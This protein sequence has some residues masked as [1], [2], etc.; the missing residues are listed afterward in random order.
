MYWNACLEALGDVEEF[1]LALWSQRLATVP[2]LHDP[3]TFISSIRIVQYKPMC[4][5]ST[6]LVPRRNVELRDGIRSTWP[7][8]RSLVSPTVFVFPSWPLVFSFFTLYSKHDH[9]TLIGRPVKVRLISGPVLH[10]EH[11]RESGYEGHIFLLVARCGRRE[12]VRIAP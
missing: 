2:L 10:P 5:A 12:H 8:C 6:P 11:I 1:D 9:I 7:A 3:G 4:Y